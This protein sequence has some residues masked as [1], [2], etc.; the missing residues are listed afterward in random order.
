MLG[1]GV[2]F[3]YKITYIFPYGPPQAITVLPVTGAGSLHPGPSCKRWA[4]E[5]A[6][7]DEVVI[8]GRTPSSLYSSIRFQ[9]RFRRQKESEHYDKPALEPLM[10]YICLFTLVMARMLNKEHNSSARFLFR[11]FCYYCICH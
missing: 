5:G 3:I 9:I 2:L 8:G 1:G 4:G 11:M 6:K 10:V 7:E